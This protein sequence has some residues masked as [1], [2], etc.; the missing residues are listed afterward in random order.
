MGF[1]LNVTKDNL[2][3]NKETME[4]LTLK[5]FVDLIDDESAKELLQTFGFILKK[6]DKQIHVFDLKSNYLGQLLISSESFSHSTDPCF[7]SM[8]KGFTTVN[9]QKKDGDKSLELLVSFESETDTRKIVGV[10]VSVYQYGEMYNS[11]KV[12]FRENYAGEQTTDIWHIYRGTEN[13]PFE[14]INTNAA[15][16]D[17]AFLSLNPISAD[18]ESFSGGFNIKEWFISRT[19]KNQGLLE[20]KE[21][22]KKALHNLEL[23][24]PNLPEYLTI[25][26]PGLKLI[27][28]NLGIPLPEVKDKK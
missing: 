10:Y 20:D 7:I 4:E 2:R 22:T 1:Y 26:N 6:V 12:L 9:E 19:H 16:K 11:L 5:E 18:G 3:E 25:H 27:Y 14:K 21:T 8:A 17:R 15:T 13:S 24:Y 28:K 23:E